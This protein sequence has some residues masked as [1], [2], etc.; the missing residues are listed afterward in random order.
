MSGKSPFTNHWRACQEAHYQEIARADDRVALNSF[1]KVM[2][3]DLGYSER[4]LKAAYVKATMHSDRVSADFVPS[5]KPVV[6]SA[7]ADQG[8]S[9]A[10][11][12]E[13]ICP[14]CMDIV[15]V[16]HDEEGQVIPDAS[17]A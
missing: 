8:Q 17:E 16:P 1:H 13:C 5:D 2:I 4:D 7:H 9:Y 6:D 15:N 14:S 12:A 11:P 10:H 3:N